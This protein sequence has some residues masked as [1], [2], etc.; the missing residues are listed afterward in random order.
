MYSH[1]TI[2]TSIFI[3]FEFKLPHVIVSWLSSDYSKAIGCR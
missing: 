3:S 2:K 1:E